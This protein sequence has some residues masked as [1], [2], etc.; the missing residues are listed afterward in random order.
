M[1]TLAQPDDNLVPGQ[2]Y[3][4]Q[5]N[6]AGLQWPP[7]AADV[8]SALTNNAPTFLSDLQVTSPFTTTLYDCQFDYSGDG[9]DVVSDVA[10]SMITAIQTGI[11]KSFTFV[12]AVPDTSQSITV[13]PSNAAQKVSDAVGAAVNNAVQGAAKT[14]A[15]AA[16][17]LLTPIEIAVGI[18]AVIVVLIIFTAGKSGGLNVSELGVSVGGRK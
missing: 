8:Q 17:N 10:S 12:G 6:S 5:F 1:A 16:Q 15:Q 14:T 9:S 13:S 11:S 18:L 3:T 2:T 4:F 7:S